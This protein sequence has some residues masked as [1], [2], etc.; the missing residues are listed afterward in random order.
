MAKVTYTHAKEIADGN[1]KIAKST[2]KVNKTFKTQKDIL[3]ALVNGQK[4]M[5]GSLNKIANASNKVAVST[6]RVNKQTLLWT[7]HTRILGGSLAVLRSKLLII[8]FG[9]ALVERSIGSLVKEYGEFEAS[10][11]RIER[12]IKSTNNA[13]NVSAK[14]V[15]AMSAAF[16]HTTGIAETLVNTSSAMLLTFT[17]IG[18]AVFPQAQEAVLDM[19]AAMYQGNVSVENLRTTSIQLGKALNDPIGGLNSLRR[20]GVAF[21]RNQKTLIKFFVNTNQ[22]AKAQAII[23][24]ELNKEF[25]GQSKIDGYA[26]SLRKFDTAIGNLKKNIG[27]ELR[28]AVE[29]LI[30]KLTDL[31][32]RF[33]PSTIVPFV[34]TMAA[35]ILA[36]RTLSKVL[37][38]ALVAQVRHITSTTRMIKVGKLAIFNYLGLTSAVR[39]ASLA[40]R[41]LTVATR[42]LTGPLGLLLIAGEG[43]FMMGKMFPKIEEGLGDTATQLGIAETRLIEYEKAQTI[44]D[45]QLE[46][47]SI[48]DALLYKQALTSI[49]K[50]STGAVKNVGLLRQ[51]WINEGIAIRATTEDLR[52]KKKLQDNATPKELTA[53]EKLADKVKAS[54]E[55]Y[56]EQTKILGMN[57]LVKKE[58]FKQSVKLFGKDEETNELLLD[59]N[60][61]LEKGTGEYYKY[62]EA[63]KAAVL[64]KQALAQE[65]QVMNQAFSTTSGFLQLNSDILQE[66]MNADVEAMKNT[67]KYKRA[68]KRG[69]DKKMAALEKEAAAKT[70]KQRQNL[71]IAEK[72]MAVAQVIIDYVRAE[73]KGFAGAGPIFGIPLAAMMKANMI[74]SIALIHQQGVMGMPKFARGGDFETTG[75]QMIMVG[76]NPGGRERVQVTPLSSPN[77]EGPQPTSN[78]TVNVSGN[79]L[80]QDFVEDELAEA[81]RDAARRGT[82]FGIT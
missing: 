27:A 82:D 73:A 36:I 33:D 15:F 61:E 21:T 25:G 30:I 46:N 8:S 20:V 9:M 74:A 43:L 40:V 23:L 32:N 56:E 80:T 47:N 48:K 62:A 14:E 53:A 5:V 35:S 3:I 76:D 6:K 63:I 51:A 29:N 65:T 11:K 7:K 78:I 68:Q 57:N 1:K 55:Q 58:L 19:A 49:G 41:G 60:V 28:P 34:T 31:A 64:A 69:D 75:P 50:S 22:V 67:A 10:Q 81:I 4:M 42:L 77:L 59:L 72:A 66:R 37:G 39:K 18:E 52:N 16:E 71:F 44:L 45:E 26:M 17:N 12:A 13:A 54:K 24:K 70:L 79:V 2:E 38:L